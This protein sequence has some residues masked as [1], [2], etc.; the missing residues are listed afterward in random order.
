MKVNGTDYSHILWKVIKFMFQ[1]TNQLY[2]YCWVLYTVIYHISHYPHIIQYSIY[3]VIYCYILLDVIHGIYNY[4]D[5]Y[6]IYKC[7][8]MEYIHFF[9][10]ILYTVGCFIKFM[11]QESQPPTRNKPAEPRTAAPLTSTGMAS[12]PRFDQWLNEKCRCI[13]LLAHDYMTSWWLSQPL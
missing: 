9:K 11:F 6:G 2:Q 1:T 13:T 5:N 7:Y 3:T 4:M 10:I 12:S 8:N